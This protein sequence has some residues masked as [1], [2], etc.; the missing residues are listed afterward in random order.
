MRFLGHFV[1]RSL[2]MVKKAAMRRVYRMRAGRQVEVMAALT[3]VLGPMTRSTR[4]AAI[5]LHFLY[6]L[7]RTEALSV[8]TRAL[9]RR[10]DPARPRQVVLH[11]VLKSAWLLQDEDVLAQVCA[12]L[13]QSRPSPTNLAFVMLRRSGHPVMQETAQAFVAQARAALDD[14]DATD[15]GQAKVLLAQLRTLDLAEEYDLPAPVRAAIEDM[16]RAP[17]A[18]RF[19]ARRAVHN[20]DWGEAWD[21][22]DRLRQLTPQDAGVYADLGDTALYFSDPLRRITALLADRRAAGAEVMGYDRLGGLYHVLRTDYRAYLLARDAQVSNQVARTHYGS[23]AARSMGQ[24]ATGFVPTSETAFV[25]G[26]DGVSDELRWSYYYPRLVSTFSRAGLSCDPRLERLFRRSFPALD[27]Y[28]VARNW[29]RA[30]TRAHDIPRD[31]VPNL[32]LATRLDNRAYAASMKADQVMFIEDVPVRDW[33]S[34]GLDGPPAEGEPP[35]ATLAPDPDRAAY[36]ASRL[37]DMAGGRLKLGLI[38]RSGLIDIQRRRHYMELP[39]F[40]PLLGPGI[41]AVSIQHQVNDMEL[42]QGNALGVNFLHDEV[43]LYNDFDEIAALTKGLDLVIGISTLP[44]EMAAAVGTECWLCAISPLGRWLRLGET[45]QRHDRLT[46]NGQ[47]VFPRTQEGYL[48]PRAAR[49][50]SIIEQMQAMLRDRGVG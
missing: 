23:A 24:G 41:C 36:W 34:R 30:Q 46:R 10:I 6:V 7:N 42:E 43:D 27:I 49:V 13:V 3:G 21:R 44:Y 8:R 28:P 14:I 38:W 5:H 12:A 37:D 9:A 32:E 1:R 15:P 22:F 48:A 2:A 19:L 4:I 35:G 16:P 18:Q 25:I 17:T 29:G 45:G 33:I 47:V 40:A 11:M 20:E 31:A 50:Q 39:D 26:R